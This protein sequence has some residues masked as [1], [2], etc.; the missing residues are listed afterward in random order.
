VKNTI[1]KLFSRFNKSEIETDKDE[2]QTAEFSCTSDE[3]KQFA[4]DIEAKISASSDAQKLFDNFKSHLDKYY[5]PSS[6]LKR[7]A[8]GLADQY[9]AEHGFVTGRS[10]AFVAD[11]Y[12]SE[13]YTE[14]PNLGL[15][16]KRN[17]QA[18]KIGKDEH[19]HK[20]H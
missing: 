20:E 8:D 3:Y 13:L 19:K 18:I 5:T 11:Q 16:A 4:A 14:E 1:I 12:L 17:G 6:L 10:A 15:G 7:I 9:L 2:R